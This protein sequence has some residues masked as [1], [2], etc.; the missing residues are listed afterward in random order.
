MLEKGG[1]RFSTKFAVSQ[2][3]QFWKRREKR[4]NKTLHWFCWK[5][6]ADQF[7]FFK[8]FLLACDA[9]IRNL[10][11]SAFLLQGFL[12]IVVKNSLWYLNFYL[13]IKAPVCQWVCLFVCSLTPP[14]RRTQRAEIL[15]DDSSWDE[16]GFR[17]KNIRLCETIRRKIKK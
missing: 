12:L 15:R 10:D 2:S 1:I 3:N 16:E 11:F 17:L 13:S 4:R 5:R 7:T 6:N 9:F 8:L 14:K